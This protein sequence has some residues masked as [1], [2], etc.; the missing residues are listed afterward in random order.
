MNKDET[1][2]LYTQGKQAWNAWAKEM[3]ERRAAME[4]AGT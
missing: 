3:L 1:L 2:A 4:A